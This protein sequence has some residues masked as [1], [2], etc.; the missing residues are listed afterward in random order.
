MSWGDLACR[1]GGPGAPSGPTQVIFLNLKWDL[2]AEGSEA[3]ITFPAVLN[4][5]S[6]KYIKLHQRVEESGVLDLA[7]TSFL[8]EPVGHISSQFHVL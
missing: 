4:T 8:P 7:Y 5:K 1:N 3:E 6:R 2:G